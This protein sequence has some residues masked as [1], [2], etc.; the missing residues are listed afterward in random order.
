MKIPEP[1]DIQTIVDEINSTS[2]P[3]LEMY[4]EWHDEYLNLPK[5]LQA[6]EKLSNGNILRKHLLA[7]KYGP[8]LY[9]NYGHEWRQDES[10]TQI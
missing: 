9:N 6:Q 7:K 8:L 5:D 4:N 1:K 2:R 3:D 10:N